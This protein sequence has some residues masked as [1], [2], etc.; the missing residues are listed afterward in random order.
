[1]GGEPT[2]TGHGEGVGVA[3]D[4]EEFSKRGRRAVAG[5]LRPAGPVFDEDH[6]A[7]VTVGARGAIDA[8]QGVYLL[9][10]RAGGHRGG[11]GR[12]P[13]EAPEIGR[14]SCRERV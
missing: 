2:R 5:G 4:H 12:G 11:R 3:A 13:E 6:R 14:A 10:G 7:G 9:R 8:G 1:M